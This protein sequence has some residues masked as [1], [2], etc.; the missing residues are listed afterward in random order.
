[1]EKFGP[2]S[3]SCSS[4]IVSL[5]IA[6]VCEFDRNITKEQTAPFGWQYDN[7]RTDAVAIVICPVLQEIDWLLSEVNRLNKNTGGG[8]DGEIDGGH[9]K[10]MEMVVPTSVMVK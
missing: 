5:N 3:G 9:D 7:C 10:P 2:F 4:T 8:M 6:P 1:M